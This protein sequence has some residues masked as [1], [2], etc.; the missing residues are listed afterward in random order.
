MALRTLWP[1]ALSVQ[2]FW[3]QTCACQYEKKW[4]HYHSGGNYVKLVGETNYC[5][6]ANWL[7]S[8]GFSAFMLVRRLPH[9]TFGPQ[10]PLDDARCALCIL[11]EKVLAQMF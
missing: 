6:V 10:A 11:K 3:L 5:P 2:L 7:M 8:L 1:P 4:A 9:S